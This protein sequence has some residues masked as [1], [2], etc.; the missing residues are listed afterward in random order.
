MQS[1][2]PSD[3]APLRL[4]AGRQ[5]A[6]AKAVIVCAAVPA[7]TPKDFANTGTAGTI[8]AHIP[9]NSVLV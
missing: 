1:A 7:E 3:P 5:I 4:K 6:T 2:C 8:I 9:A